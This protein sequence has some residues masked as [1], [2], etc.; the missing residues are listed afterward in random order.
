MCR[1]ANAQPKKL[2]CGDCER[3]RAD[4]FAELMRR[5]NAHRRRDDELAAVC[6]RCAGCRQGASLYTA[7][8]IVGS[9]CCESLDCRVLFARA[10]LVACIEDAQLA[11]REI[12]LAP[13]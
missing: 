10:R 11:A 1:V 3:N 4:T 9:G 2:L 8:E 6:R 7:G 12:S 13:P 5:L